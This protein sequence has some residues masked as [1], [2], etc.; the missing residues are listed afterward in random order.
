MS[1]CA[2]AAYRTVPQ[3]FTLDSLQASFLIAPKS[4][5]PMLFRVNRLSN[6]RRF[7][8]RSVTLEQ[9]GVALLHS[10]VNFVSKSPWSGP[11]M[12]STS[13][14]QTEHTISEITLDDLDRD[15][16]RLGSFMEFQRLPLHHSGKILDKCSS[17]SND[18]D[19]LAGLENKLQ[20]GVATS[21]CKIFPRMQDSAGSMNHTLGIIN[22]SD[23]HV[24]D[25]A[26]QLNE[27]P[28]GM[29]AIGDSSRTATDNMLKLGTTLNHSIHFRR[30]DGYR[31]D[32]MI[33]VEVEPLWSQD[34]RTMLATQIFTAQG[35]LIATCTQEVGQ[36]AHRAS[37][38]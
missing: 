30:H 12:S 14:R 20:K 7:M 22:L 4:D 15:R 1:E 5:L 23:Y 36:E 10:I 32:E 37:I 31:A 19:K 11:A 33:Y 38:S 24:M 13:T 2:A 35:E 8:V 28:I 27:I 16:T 21:A 17:C 9:N 29:Y 34:A 26:L 6:G 25:A 3:D 18:S